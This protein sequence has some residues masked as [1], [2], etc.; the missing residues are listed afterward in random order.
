MSAAA[1]LRGLWMTNTMYE[2][3][4]R[5]MVAAWVFFVLAVGMLAPTAM[6][7]DGLGNW[8]AVEN[9]PDCKFYNLVEGSTAPAQ[10][11]GLCKNGFVQGEGTITYT[12]QRGE[13]RLSGAFID[14]IMNGYGELST[15][16][17]RDGKRT[18]TQSNGEYKNGF[19]DGQGLV[20]IEGLWAYEGEF[21]KGLPDG[22]IVLQ[23]DD[24]FRL[25]GVFKGWNKT[26]GPGILEIQGDFPVRFTGEFHGPVKDLEIVGEGVLETYGDQGYRYVGEFKG[27]VKH[28]QGVMKFNQGTRYEGAF[29]EGKR[30][31]YGK[32]TLA[33][34]NSCEGVWSKGRLIYGLGMM[35]GE[36]V[37]CMVVNDTL[38]FIK[39]D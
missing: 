11:T 7:K 1:F 16:V 25:E 17:V 2:K 20:E 22:H 28:G 36:P 18:A 12:T 5:F 13:T 10:W 27:T 24:L 6:A 15:W 8:Q 21:K 14:G 32:E 37:P 34:G 35:D 39:N 33:N 31:G 23:A 26:N 19:M 29:Q 9:Q 4:L 38:S 3:N 30:H